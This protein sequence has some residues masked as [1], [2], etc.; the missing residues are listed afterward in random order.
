[1]ILS[2]IYGW[3]SRQLNFVMTY[4]QAPVENPLNMR[5]PQGYHCKG[6]TKDTHVL[7]LIRTI[8]GQK[9]AGRVWNKYLDEGMKEMG[10][11]PSD[12]DPCLYH[13]RNVVMLIYIDDCLVFSPDPKLIYKTISDLRNSS[14]NFEI[15][16]Q[17]D[18]SDF[19]CIEVTHLKDGSIKLTQPHLIV[20]LNDL[21]LKENTKEKFHSRPLI[22]NPAPRCGRC[23][24]G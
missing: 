2:L 20:I 3:A 18:V 14:K 15:D 6:I 21:H 16:D 8:Y 1:M 22:P 24:Y 4:P 7:K 19:L 23:R 5:L 9:Q 12:Y 13:K 10:F 17:G 11:T